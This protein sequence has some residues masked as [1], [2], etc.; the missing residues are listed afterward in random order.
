[1]LFAAPAVAV[2]TR[3]VR[4]SCY[5]QE[6]HTMATKSPVRPHH[7]ETSRK[8]WDSGRAERRLPDDAS[9]RTLRREFAWVHARNRESETAAKF[10]HHDVTAEGKPGAANIRACINGIAILNGGRGGANIPEGDRPAIYRHLAT[11]IRDAGDDPAPL[12]NGR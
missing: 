7:T 6:V 11:H 9:E 12:K 8:E 1:L 5:E 3:I 2:L 10:P 4:S